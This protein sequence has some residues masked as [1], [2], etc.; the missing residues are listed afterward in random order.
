MNVSARK[1]FKPF[2]YKMDHAQPIGP[3]FSFNRAIDVL[4]SFELN[5]LNDDFDMKNARR[6]SVSGLAGFMN[7]NIDGQSFQMV[8]APQVAVSY[9][10]YFLTRIR[11]TDING[12]TVTES[13]LKSWLS[14]GFVQR[15][16]VRHRTTEKGEFIVDLVSK[17][18][19]HLL[20][21]QAPKV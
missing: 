15:P 19:F 6:L 4:N 7:R 14:D 12:L 17:A 16:L 2:I 13:A 8:A 9:L 11:V 5:T 1:D 18:P 20:V 21:S 10:G 3:K